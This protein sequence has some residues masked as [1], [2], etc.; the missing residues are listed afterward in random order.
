VVAARPELAWADSR[1]GLREV[2]AAGVAG[3]RFGYFGADAGGGAAYWH[4]TW[5]DRGGL[6]L[7]VRVSVAFPA[8]DARRWPEM[9]FAT[10]IRADEGC[11]FVMLTQSCLGR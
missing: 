7:L 10:A 3:V 11:Q 6:P 1:A 9:I 8:G 4:D 2:L 5:R